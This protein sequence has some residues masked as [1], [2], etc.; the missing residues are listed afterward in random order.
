MMTPKQIAAYARAMR[1]EGVLVVRLGDVEIHLGPPPM[2][3]TRRARKGK[4]SPD[5]GIEEELVTDPDEAMTFAHTEGFE[6]V[7][8]PRGKH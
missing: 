8:L 5:D 2:V 7:G 1:R 4:S 3:P 6:P